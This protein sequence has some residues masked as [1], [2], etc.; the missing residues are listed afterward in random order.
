MENT[1]TIIDPQIISAL[2]QAIGAILAALLAALFARS[3]VKDA[4]S[5]HFHSYSE[6]SHDLRDITRKAQSDIFIVVAIGDRLLEKY[7]SEF[8]R[9][10]KAGICIRY[11]FLDHSG[12]SNLDTYLHDAPS[13]DG[14]YLSALKRLSELKEKY[15]SLMNV[16]IFPNYMSASYIGVDIWPTP[17][18]PSILPSSVIQ[19][20]LYQYHVAAKDSPITYLSPKTDKKQ[21][22]STVQSIKDMWGAAETDLTFHDLKEMCQPL[23][24]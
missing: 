11:L 1:P 18:T 10:L 16:R 9:Q 20:M 15:P 8:E 13:R 12:F 17:P 24:V 22:N 5:P 2:I 19:T 23:H 21:Y 4:V 3:I 14:A 6:S 7:M